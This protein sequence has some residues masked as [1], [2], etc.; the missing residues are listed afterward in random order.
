MK[1]DDEESTEKTTPAMLQPGGY[2]AKGARDLSRCTTTLT[3]H[4]PTYLDLS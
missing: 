3:Q 1:S 2:Y 4:E